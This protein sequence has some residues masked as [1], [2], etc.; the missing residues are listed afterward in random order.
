M[1]KSVLIFLLAWSV[2]CAAR[3]HFTAASTNPSDSTREDKLGEG[4]KLLLRVPEGVDAG[5]QVLIQLRLQNITDT[6][7]TFQEAG[8][9]NEFNVEMWKDGHPAPRTEFGRMLTS[10]LGGVRSAGF[11]TVNA[12]EWRDYKI[13]VSR[14]YDM[15][16]AGS[17]V[18][19][20]SRNVPK[21]GGPFPERVLQSGEVASA[22]ATIH[23]HDVNLDFGT[24][25]KLAP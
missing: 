22:K 14:Q 20:V 13:D 21:L 12:G 23:V 1:K 4:F 8:T 19:R 5:S 18:I 11:P 2:G 3:D 7:M 25:G 15:S 17:Y 10:H 9:D 24:P 6:P 16:V